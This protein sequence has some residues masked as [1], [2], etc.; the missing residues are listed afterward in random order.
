MKPKKHQ[1]LP[2]NTKHRWFHMRECRNSYEPNELELSGN[3]EHPGISKIEGNMSWIFFRFLFFTKTKN[4][5]SHV[6]NAQGW[7]RCD[8]VHIVDLEGLSGG[9]ALFWKASYIVEV[10]HSDKRIIDFKVK[11]ESFWRFFFYLFCLWR[12]SPR[13]KKRWLGASSQNRNNDM[14]PGLLLEIWMR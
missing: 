1:K 4:S 11:L 12:S 6:I 7:M 5:S 9:L 13:T 14:R 10:S 2:S 3:G 8:H